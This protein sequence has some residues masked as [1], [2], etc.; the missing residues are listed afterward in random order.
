MVPFPNKQFFKGTP[1]YTYSPARIPLST[2]TI[3]VRVPLSTHSP[4]KGTSFHACS[5]W[6]KVWAR[7]IWADDKPVP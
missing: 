6:E 3:D 2:H 4:C 5:P 7:Q 1:F